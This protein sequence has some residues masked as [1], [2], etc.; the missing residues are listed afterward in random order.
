MKAISKNSSDS[1]FRIKK[2]INTELFIDGT[3]GFI[4]RREI[5]RRIK[6]NILIKEW[7]KKISDLS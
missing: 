5:K 4:N 1:T 6:K 2:R 3:M 7:I